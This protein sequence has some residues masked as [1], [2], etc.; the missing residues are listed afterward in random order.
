[1]VA[2]VPRRTGVL[3]VRA[4]LEGER[5]GTLRAR[6]T[7]TL[8]LSRRDVA[9]SAASSAEEIQRA[10]RAWLDEFSRMTIR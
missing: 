5:P 9:V 6:I 1:M 4:W 10:V 3:V 2:A 8:D 7:S